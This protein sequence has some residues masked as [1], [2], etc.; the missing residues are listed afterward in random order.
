MFEVLERCFLH[1]R[2]PERKRIFDFFAGWVFNSDVPNQRAAGM[3]FIGAWC[4]EDVTQAIESWIDREKRV[5]RRRVN[6][7]DFLLEA[8]M[9][10]L[11]AE[12]IPVSP[13]KGFRTGEARGV[14]VSSEEGL[15]ETVVD[16]TKRMRRIV[17]G[18]APAGPAAQIPQ[19]AASTP[20]AKAPRVH[21]GGPGA[22]R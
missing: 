19:P 6:R 16:Q 7:S 10:K 12:R 18:P 22:S 17:D 8:V 4:P 9:E 11:E 3:K 1:R 20:P 15:K 2:P 14:G 13:E 5:S 21:R